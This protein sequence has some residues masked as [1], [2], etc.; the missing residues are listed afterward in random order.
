VNDWPNTLEQKWQPR[1]KA[2][3]RRTMKLRHTAAQYRTM[4][5]ERSHEQTREQAAVASSDLLGMRFGVWR[6][7]IEAYTGL[8]PT[9]GMAQVWIDCSA[10]KNACVVHDLDEIKMTPKYPRADRRSFYGIH[11]QH[12]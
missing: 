4:S 7:D 8:F 6:V 12:P 1:L 2:S 5:T 10:Q 3:F 9:L 11:K